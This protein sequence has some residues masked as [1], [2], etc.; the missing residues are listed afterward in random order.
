MIEDRFREREDGLSVQSVADVAVPFLSFLCCTAAAIHLVS[1]AFAPRV[2]ISRHLCL[3]WSSADIPGYWGDT[4]KFHGDHQC[5]FKALFPVSIGT[6]ALRQFA[7]KHFLSA[8]KHFHADMSNPT[9]LSSID[10]HTHTHTHIYMY[11]YIY[12]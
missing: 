12:I 2:T 5:V 8:V 9:K 7:V 10:T 4:E 3:S 11:I 1:Q 6:V